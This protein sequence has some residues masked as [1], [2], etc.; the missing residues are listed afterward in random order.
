MGDKQKDIIKEYKE[1][2]KLLNKH[3]NL[4]HNYDSPTITDSD[5]DQLKKKII[6]LEKNYI[7]LKKYGSIKNK[8]GAKP[9]SN[10][11]KINHLKPMLS[12][13]NAFEKEDMKNMGV[14]GLITN[15]L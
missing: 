6:L 2:I 5:F 12:L 3:N 8:V 1:S 15:Y 9:I 10:F 13:S 7:F 4:Y 14:S 11:K